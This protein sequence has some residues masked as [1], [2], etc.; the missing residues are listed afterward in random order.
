LKVY[1]FY[2]VK[3]FFECFVRLCSL[4]EA[5]LCENKDFLRLLS[6]KLWMLSTV[7]HVS[8]LVMFYVFKLLIFNFFYFNFSTILNVWIMK[9]I[10][11]LKIIVLQ[12]Y[13]G[14]YILFYIL[15]SLTNILI[16]FLTSTKGNLFLLLN[17]LIKW[18]FSFYRMIRNSL[19][20]K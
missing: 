3:S 16:L 4:V 19:S 14:E 20:F 13:V 12:C 5:L 6:L 8:E 9:F 17:I 2:Y 1:Y 11:L 18:L 15:L 10:F 7:R